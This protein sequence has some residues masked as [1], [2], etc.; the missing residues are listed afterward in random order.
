MPGRFDA[1]VIGSGFGGAVTACRLA[2]KGLRILTLERGRRWDAYPYGPR[3]AKDAWWWDQHH[4]EKH[5]G[6]LD[7]R[8]FKNMWVAQ[9]AGVGGGSLIYANISIDAKPEVFNAGWPAEITYE[10][11]KPYYQRVAGMLRLETVP[12]NQVPERYKLMKEA[13]Q[14]LGYGDRFKPLP[15]AVT[16]RK[17]LDPN[18][19]EP[20]DDKHSVTWTNPQGRQQGTCTHCGNCVIGCQVR[21]KNT[22]DLNYLAQAENHHAEIRAS[23]L[24]RYIEPVDGRYRV[25]FDRILGNG[26]VLRGDET[27]PRVIIA[28]GSLGSTE[29]LLR[30]RDEY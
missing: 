17:D 4:P 23:H 9:C 1:I 3:N 16:Y 21:A 10:E 25:V 22:L 27:A 30:C 14:K 18:R 11:L 6:W 20:F 13:A 29:M 5:N 8:F 28:A 2:E 24:V 7:F 15:T 12:E 26:Q 19:T